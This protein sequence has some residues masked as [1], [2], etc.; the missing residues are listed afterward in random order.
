MK[1]FVTVACTFM[2]LALL[3]CLPADNKGECYGMGNCVD[4][5][6]F[7]DMFG[8]YEGLFPSDSSCGKAI[9][10]TLRADSTYQMEYKYLSNE[11]DTFC[12]EGTFHLIQEKVVIERS[13]L[14]S[15]KTYYIYVHGNLVLADSLGNAK[16]S[17]FLEFYTLERS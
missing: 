10:L 14:P 17:N 5:S 8:T 6:T 3:S 16:R 13:A 7:V 11:D 15:E 1:T 4:T 2:C 9:S 12:E